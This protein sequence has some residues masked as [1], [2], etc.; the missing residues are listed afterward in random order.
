MR[1][2]VIIEYENSH[3]KRKGGTGKTTLSTNL[4]AYLS[5][6][7]E[8]VLVD[9][10]VEEPNSGLFIQGELIHEEDKFKMIPDG[11]KINV[12]YVGC[13]RMYATFMQ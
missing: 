8:V 12:R 3:C 1:T 10:D 6:E 2:Y 5:E 11:L 13:V 7:A 9:L 4:A